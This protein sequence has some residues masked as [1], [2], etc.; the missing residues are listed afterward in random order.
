M[1]P[2]FRSRSRLI[3][4]SALLSVILVACG[5][6][7]EPDPI[8]VVGPDSE[9]A[10]PPEAEESEA[11]AFEVVG[12]LDL[13]GER[14][15]VV[16][17]MRLR[18]MG[19]A[20]VWFL[21]PAGRPRLLTHVSVSGFV[22]ARLAGSQLVVRRAEGDTLVVVD[23]IRDA[24]RRS[25][26]GAWRPFERSTQ[27]GMIA[28]PGPNGEVH[29]AQVTR[30]GLMGFDLKAMS[31]ALRFDAQDG[32]SSG[33]LEVQPPRSPWV[34]PVHGSAR[35]TG[36]DDVD[37][38]GLGDILVLD[39]CSLRIVSM[40]TGAVRSVLRPQVL[41]QGEPERTAYIGGV[42]PTVFLS[43]RSNAG[44]VEE[45]HTSLLS[46]DLVHN[47]LRGLVRLPSETYTP[48]WSKLGHWLVGEDGG[49]GSAGLA[50]TGDGEGRAWWLRANGV[51]DEGGFPFPGQYRMGVSGS[52]AIIDGRVLA[53]LGTTPKP[54][55]WD[56]GSLTLW[57]PDRVEPVRVFRMT[58]AGMR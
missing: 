55:V 53:M 14:G 47:A 28:R 4:G 9:A 36:I 52:V 51:T 6:S 56:S 20:E 31:S 10:S 5:R 25:N 49:S 3:W 13:D 8:P 40:L 18:G 26:H 54:G 39:G 46:I 16:L 50:L 15:F 43:F 29:V 22:E 7:A 1:G 48:T 11:R 38:D 24:D 34:I 35:L 41:R 57:S 44:A 23:L 32:P 42:D 17:A 58:P 21:T 30:D 19:R 33:M 2:G 27:H 12:T 37:G 45:T